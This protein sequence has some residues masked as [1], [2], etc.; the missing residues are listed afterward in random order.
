[1]LH[2]TASL[3][4][5]IVGAY[6]KRNCY[7]FVLDNDRDWLLISRLAQDSTHYHDFLLLK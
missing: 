6:H 5:N 4:I 1:M 3:E 7:K 2:P